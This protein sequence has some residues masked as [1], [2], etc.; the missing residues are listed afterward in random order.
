M[1]IFSTT[2]CR[3]TAGLLAI[4]LL[5]VPVAA[6][7]MTTTIEGSLG[8]R[9]Q[10]RGETRY[11]DSTSASF[12]EEII[13]QVYYHNRELED[14]GNIAEDLNINVDLPTSAGQTQNVGVTI[15]G[16]NTNT[17][18]DSVTVNLNRPDAR[19]EFIPGS[20]KWK[21]NDGTNEDVN[22][23]TENLSDDI[24]LNPNGA[25]IE[26][27]QPCFNFDATVTFRARVVVP[28]VEVTKEVRV[29]DSG[30][31]FFNELN[32]VEPGTELE[33]RI[34]AKNNGNT[35]ISDLTV[36]D[37]LPPYLHYVQDSAFV[38]NSNTGL[39]GRNIGNNIVSGGTILSD[40]YAPGAVA[41][42]V[43]RA[44]VSENIVN[45]RCGV[46]TLGN[47][48]LA[49]T[50]GAPV[51]NDYATITV[52]TNVE[53]NQGIDV[54]CEQLTAEKVSENVFDFTVENSDV[55]EGIELVGYNFMF[56]ADHDTEED[57]VFNESNTVRHAYEKAGDYTVVVTVIYVKDET[58]FISTSADCVVEVTVSEGPSDDQPTCK[59]LQVVQLSD[60]KFRFEAEA[61]NVDGSAV[62]Q[63]R[64]NFGDGSDVLVTD[65]STVEH[66]YA[67][68]G[69]YVARLSI[70]FDQDGELL[71][72]VTRES[73][74]KE[75]VVSGEE[76]PEELPNTGAG[77]AIAA[78]AGTGILGQGV[79]MF[80]SSRRKL[81]ETLLNK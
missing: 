55:P 74:R 81:T 36:G 51:V 5:M 50:A 21:H 22:I 69:N 59:Q 62:K 7:A 4:V 68:D 25:V 66:A 80:V 45:E 28:A 57:F 19:L 52:D 54:T 10:T 27:A 76:N 65:K 1:N 43:F 49:S 63:Y 16:S 29:A 26:D 31:D 38:Y 60:K 9:N 30:T 34:K 14:S 64:Y 73:C 39:A 17:V 32:D 2:K 42:V 58:V 24:V 20:V 15:K 6:S 78:V 48:G 41:T 79:N 47:E 35:T 8:V 56:D 12:D 40:N 23:V 70:D 72:A 46:V 37:N 33:Y 77:S 53:C 75:I 3:I 71:S 61:S 44:T 67:N 13:F 11:E 18:T